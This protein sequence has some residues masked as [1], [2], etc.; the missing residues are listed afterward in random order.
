MEYELIA[1]TWISNAETLAAPQIHIKNLFDE[2]KI[3]YSE[4][5]RHYH[6]LRHIESMISLLKDDH[7]LSESIFLATWFNDFIYDPLRN[8]NAERSVVIAQARLTELHVNEICISKVSRLILAT[9]RHEYSQKRQMDEQSF[10][11]ADMAILGASTSS[12]DNDSTNVR[13]E[14]SVVPEDIYRN[15]RIKFL[16]KTLEMPN[17]FGTKSFAD[18]FE[19]TARKNIKREIKTLLLTE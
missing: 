1:S 11:D 17:I 14:F 12:Y 8:D 6:T 10:L 18:R 2:L 19:D 16:R 5:G 4:N 9:K 3:I 7:C 15:G 13:K